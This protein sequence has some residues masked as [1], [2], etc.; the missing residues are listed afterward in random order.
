MPMMMIRAA[1]ASVLLVLAPVTQV[2]AQEQLTPAEAVVLGQEVWNGR[3]TVFKI[4]PESESSEQKYALC[5]AAQCFTI[6]NVAYC[7]CE[8]KV[9]Q[10]ISLP[11]F[12]PADQAAESGAIGDVCDLMAVSDQ[13]NF[14][15]S[16]YSLPPQLQKSYDGPDALALYTCPG[17]SN[18]SAQCDGGLCID[19]TTGTNWPFLGEIGPDE[20]VC[21]C[22]IAAA[23]SVG[24]QFVGPADCDQAFFDQYC[25]VRP[26]GQDE[27]TIP[28]GTQLAVGAVTG[29]GVI[30]TKLLSGSVPALNTCTFPAE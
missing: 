4:C 13:G 5:A 21:S 27:T 28:T 18:L 22:P 24:F 16:T 3:P 29:S 9:G 7:K 12:F 11:F 30:L 15:V 14:L 6:D 23:P 17:A 10:S 2:T 8:R 19:G 20:I 25:G 1:F 26:G